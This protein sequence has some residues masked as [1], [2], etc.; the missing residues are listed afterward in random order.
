[1]EDAAAAVV[2]PQPQPAQRV[3]DKPLV[4]K[5]VLK[6]RRPGDQAATR[7]SIRGKCGAGMNR[8]STAAEKC[9]V[10]YHMHMCKRA[11]NLDRLTENF[12]TVLE[13]VHRHSVMKKRMITQYNKRKEIVGISYAKTVKRGN[14]WKRSLPLSW[15]A[16]TAFQNVKIPGLSRSSRTRLR[17]VVAIS[18]MGIQLTMLAK[19]CISM[20][21]DRAVSCVH[22]MKFDEA[23]HTFNVNVNFRKSKRLPEALALVDGK[24]RKANKT[25]N[26]R[27]VWSVLVYRSMLLMAWADGR[28][29]ML[30]LVCI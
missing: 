25:P 8:G 23:S 15:Y 4:E 16:L 19:L 28:I 1:M 9:F 27:S 14:R 17:R 5:T 30:K 24:F 6:G 26:E 11:K 18:V 20:Q 10:S 13:H 29:M 21:A 7:L 3:L 22:R 12:D 2:V